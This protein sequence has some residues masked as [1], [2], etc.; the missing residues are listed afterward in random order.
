MVQAS[1]KNIWYDTLYI[2]SESLQLYYM[3]TQG[4]S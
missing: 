2:L 1:S 4:H 3:Y